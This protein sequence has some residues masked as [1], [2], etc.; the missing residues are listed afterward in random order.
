[1]IGFSH[2]PA[3]LSMSHE[4]REMNPQK[5]AFCGAHVILKGCLTLIPDLLREL[6]FS[7]CKVHFL[8]IFLKLGSNCSSVPQVLSWI[9]PEN[10]AVITRSSQPLVG[11]S[12]K[13]NKDDERYLELIRETNGQLS[14]LTIYDARPSVNAVAN[15]VSECLRST[16]ITVAKEPFICNV[17]CRY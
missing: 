12:G 4:C 1:M 6:N 3:G 17:F 7:R 15:K 9:H 11:M 5:Y 10:Q 16:T 8:P 13:R 14:K 2:I